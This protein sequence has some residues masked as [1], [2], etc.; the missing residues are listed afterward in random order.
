[1]LLGALK[2]VVASILWALVIRR[3][4]VSGEWGMPL[5]LGFWFFIDPHTHAELYKTAHTFRNVDN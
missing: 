1:M 5:G 4:G 2:R 3:P